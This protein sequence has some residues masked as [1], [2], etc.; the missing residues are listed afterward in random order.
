[1][2]HGTRWLGVIGF[3]AACSGGSE[4]EDASADAAAQ[5]RTSAA[6]AADVANGV[7]ETIAALRE[8]SRGSSVPFTPPPSTA[9][10][11]GP[12]ATVGTEGAPLGGLTDAQA[13]AFQVGKA[14]FIEAEEARRGSGA[15]VQPRKLWR[16]PFATGLRRY[17]SCGQS[18]GGIGQFLQQGAVVHHRQR[19]GA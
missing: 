4:R 18:A 16:L 17:Q 13:H 7:R 10:D 15:D 6:A 1:M 11:P 5:D 2:R 12:R 9:K 8:G 19:P 3:L 14:D